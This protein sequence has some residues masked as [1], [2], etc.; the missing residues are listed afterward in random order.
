[1]LE[2]PEELQIKPTRMVRLQLTQAQIDVLV[3]Y[4]MCH[5]YQKKHP[6]VS[7]MDVT[8]QN[9]AAKWAIMDRLGFAQ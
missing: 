9:L 7:A 1:M 6:K 8:E 5:G 4:A 2:C 3:N